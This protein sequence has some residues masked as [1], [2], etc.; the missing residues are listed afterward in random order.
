LDDGKGGRG[1]NRALMEMRER[2]KSGWEIVRNV[3]SVAGGGQCF[4][5]GLC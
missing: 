1:T 2:Q 3:G 4:G 5:F